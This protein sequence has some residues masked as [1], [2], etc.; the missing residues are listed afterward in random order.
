MATPIILHIISSLEQGGAETCLY[1]LVASSDPS[2]FRHIIVAFSGNGGLESK[3][4]NAGIEVYNLTSQMTYVNVP[5]AAIR[6]LR[7]IKRIQ[8]DVIQSWMYHSNLLACLAK[9]VQPN[10]P[11]LWSIHTNPDLSNLRLSQKIIVFTGRF[12][13]WIPIRTIYVSKESMRQHKRLGYNTKKRFY[14]PNGIPIDYFKSKVNSN[15][16]QQLSLKDDR[17]IVSYVKR[18]VKGNGKIWQQFFLEAAEKLV[19]RWP[20]AVFLCV[21]RGVETKE[22]GL[23]EFVRKRG[24]ENRIFLFGEMQDVRKAYAS[25][26]IYVS[27]SGREGLPLSV[28]EAMSAGIPCVVTNVGDSAYLVGDTG[29]VVPFND[30]DKLAQAIDELIAMTPK[31]RRALG[32]R[33]AKRA[34]EHFSLQKMVLAYEELYRQVLGKIALK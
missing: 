26:D 23:I 19:T 8:P 22:A 1:Q 17:I 33:A 13:E 12:F 21:G 32:A 30:I 28:I 2:Q 10:L 4:R 6:F 20:K 14:I 18:L 24:L 16:R 7:L 15:L 11:I 34:A 3:I 25:T 9:I 5:S 27:A 29:K 31:E